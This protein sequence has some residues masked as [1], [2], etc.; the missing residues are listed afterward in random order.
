MRKSTIIL[1]I[2]AMAAVVLMAGFK[3]I[4][5]SY[6]QPA[7]SHTFSIVQE[8]TGDTE[9]DVANYAA[10]LRA[11]KP[12]Y[13][14][15]VIPKGKIPS[16]TLPVDCGVWAYNPY[17]SGSYV[18]GEGEISC[19]SPHPYL[20]VVVG[21][22]YSSSHYASRSKSCHYTTKCHYYAFYP[23]TPGKTWHTDVSGYTSGWSAYYESD[24]VYI[25]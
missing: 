22:G 24:G 8:E 14:Q 3:A 7:G 21:V 23:Y 1:S 13:R 15:S 20:E 6:A 19:A 17:R 16:P 11:H 9:K 10:A 25:P 5:K 18:I 4:P 12:F 2:L